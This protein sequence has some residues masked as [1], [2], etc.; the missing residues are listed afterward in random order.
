MIDD[1]V[2]K[3]VSEP[4]RIFTSRAEYR[5]SL[6]ADNADERLTG[7]GVRFGCVGPERA[8]LH[9]D[10]MARLECRALGDEDRDGFADGAGG[11]RKS[12]S[13]RTACAAPRS[14]SPPSRI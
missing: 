5:L 7:K 3:G 12:R 8:A 6:R 9:G 13:T 14:S 11:R 10:A 2:T 1:L 4:Y